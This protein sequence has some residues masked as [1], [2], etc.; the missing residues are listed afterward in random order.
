MSICYGLLPPR[1][2]ICYCQNLSAQHV[3]RESSF[4]GVHHTLK[5]LYQT[6]SEGLYFWRTTPHPELKSIPL[7]TVLSNEHDLLHTQQQQH[8][9]L[10]SH[11]MSNANWASCICTQ[12]SFTGS[13]INLPVPRLHTR[14][15][16]R[17][18]SQ[19]HPWNL[20]SW[21]HTN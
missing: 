6:R 12:H 11:G 15:N 10:N 9:A 21:Q 3:P 16:S 5:Y 7:P 1:P 2:L 17:I 19:P 20:N 8:N 13:L 18:P 4:E 14:H